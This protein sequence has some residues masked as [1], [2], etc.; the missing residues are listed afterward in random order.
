MKKVIDRIVDYSYIEIADIPK[1]FMKLVEEVGEWSASYLESIGF[2]ASK[3]PKTRQELEDHLLEEGA[4]TLIMVYDLLFKMGYSPEQIE[5]KM[6][7]KL[8]AWDK[9]LVDRGL[10]LKTETDEPED[11][12]NIIQNAVQCASCGEI[13]N[14][15]HVHDFVTCTCPLRIG[16]DGGGDYLKRIGDSSKIIE[17]SLTDKSSIEEMKEK[18]L[19]GTYGKNGNEPLRWVKLCDC[20]TEHL[21]AILSNA[22]PGIIHTN[23]INEILDSRK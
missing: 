4:D 7:E 1:R 17:L 21:Q 9:I 18:L 13:M 20:S 16:A 12:G 10:I 3:T 8:N 5:A 11:S 15:T 6:D 23:I 14:S 2:K 22:R 19:W